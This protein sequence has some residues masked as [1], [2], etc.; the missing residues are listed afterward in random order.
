MDTKS[1]QETAEGHLSYG[2]SFVQ[3]LRERHQLF[4]FLREVLRPYGRRKYKIFTI[5]MQL[6]QWSEEFSGET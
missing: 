2:W 3:S 6:V 5:E 4:L 1:F